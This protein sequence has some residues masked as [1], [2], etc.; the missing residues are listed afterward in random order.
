[1]VEGRKP[2][3][4]RQVMPRPWG[5]DNGVAQLRAP[6]LQK[7]ELLKLLPTLPLRRLPSMLGIGR[8]V[9]QAMGIL[10]GQLSGPTLL[11]TL[12]LKEGDLPDKAL[13]VF[14]SRRQCHDVLHHPPHHIFR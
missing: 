2:H 3:P 4:L 12:A 9:R 6:G 8:H 7:G 5:S 10:L 14:M 11:R 13:Y 1:M